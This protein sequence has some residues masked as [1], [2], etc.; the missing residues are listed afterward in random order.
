MNLKGKTALVTGGSKGIGYGVAAALIQEGLNVT[1]NTEKVTLY[2]QQLKF[3]LSTCPTVLEWI[4][5][6]NASIG[7]YASHLFGPLANV[8][9]KPH[10]D[11]VTRAHNLIFD[12]VLDKK[13]LADHIKLLLESHLGRPLPDPPFALEAL[14]FLPTAYGGLGVKNPYTTLNI[15]RNVAP[16]PEA[17][18]KAF[19]EAEARYFDVAAERFH[20][21]GPAGREAKRAAIFDDD[22]ERMAAVLGEGVDPEVFLTRERCGEFRE[23]ADYYYLFGPPPVPQSPDLIGA[24]AALL[25]EPADYIDATEKVGDEVFRLAG[26]GGM[27]RWSQLSGEDRWVLQMYSEECIE[28]YGGLEVWERE[29]VPMEALKMVRGSYGEDDEDEDEDDYSSVV[30]EV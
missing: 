21:L 18:F 10:L 16:E 27:K 11:A 15:A 17:G 7:T 26:V 6:W 1:I 8:F 30:S 29:G 9:G 24:Y 20:A 3:Q 12:I 5:V 13:S 14:A 22:A 4:R 23:R 2:A 19:L 25:E 28:L